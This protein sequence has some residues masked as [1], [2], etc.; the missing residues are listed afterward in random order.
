MQQ[1]HMYWIYPTSFP[2]QPVT[3]S[4]IL[5]AVVWM[6]W[7]SPT[8]G[9]PNLHLVGVTPTALTEA[10][11][12]S[13]STS[14]STRPSGSTPFVLSWG[15]A[16]SCVVKCDIRV[17]VCVILK[18]QHGRKLH[19]W[20]MAPREKSHAGLLEGDF[21]EQLATIFSWN[22]KTKWQICP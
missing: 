13:A 7:I 21:K 22:M 1:K 14:P 3:C 19:P 12:P 18:A 5:S 10:L 6:S 20:R 16:S 17:E 2:H 9:R 15:H 4:T 8:A 11:R